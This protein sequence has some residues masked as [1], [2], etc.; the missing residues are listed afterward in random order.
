MY[1]DWTSLQ[2]EIQFDKAN[3]SVLQ[4]F[5]AIVGVKIIMHIKWYCMFYY[6]TFITYAKHSNSF[7][8]YRTK[9][10]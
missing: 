1:S 2:D 10:C 4:K 8:T 5:P 3:S 7:Q 9:V 6:I